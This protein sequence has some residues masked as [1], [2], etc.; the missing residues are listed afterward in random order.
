[1]VLYIIG[2]GL[3]DERDITVKGLEAVQSCARVYL[4]SYTSLL[5]VGKERLVFHC[6][7]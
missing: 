7:R 2:I 6:K 5:S 3:A 4:D 1:M